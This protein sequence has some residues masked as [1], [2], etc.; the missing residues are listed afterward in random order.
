MLLWVIVTQ[1][2]LPTFKPSW[3]FSKEEEKHLPLPWVFGTLTKRLLDFNTA[4]NKTEALG[5]TSA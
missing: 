4:T 3:L 2:T 5:A 1:E